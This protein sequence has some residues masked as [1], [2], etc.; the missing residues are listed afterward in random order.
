MINYFPEINY[1][2]DYIDSYI[3]KVMN[4]TKYDYPVIDEYGVKRWFNEKGELHRD[5]GP[6]IIL[7]DGSVE[8]YQNGKCHR[9]DGPAIIDANG[10]R[11]YYQNGRCHRL[12]GPAV[13]WSN[14]REEYWEYG[15]RIK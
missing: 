11:C 5:N 2:K 6:A 3:N 1:N 12:D 4:L 13:I 10:T 15:K 8:Y 9:E 14:V 7:S